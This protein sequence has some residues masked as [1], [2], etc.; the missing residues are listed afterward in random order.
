M[1]ALF[2]FT[3]RVA[4]ADRAGYY[5]TRWDQATPVTVLAETR[6]KALAKAKTVMGSPP[7]GR[8]WAIDVRDISEVDTRPTAAPADEQPLT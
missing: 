7:A 5:M 6:D 2:E 8:F 1:T 4:A 3:L